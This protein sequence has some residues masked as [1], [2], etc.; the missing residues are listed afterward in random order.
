MRHVLHGI[1]FFRSKKNLFVSFFCCKVGFKG[2][3]IVTECK[4]RHPD[5][6]QVDGFILLIYSMWLKYV[7]LGMLYHPFL[8]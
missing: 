4:K 3:A 1:T 8:P 6:P 5:G 2:Y 7:Q